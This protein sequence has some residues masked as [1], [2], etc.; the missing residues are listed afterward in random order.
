VRSSSTTS[1]ATRFTSKVAALASTRS[2]TTGI[3]KIWST[4]V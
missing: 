3:M 1:I 2:C 4:V